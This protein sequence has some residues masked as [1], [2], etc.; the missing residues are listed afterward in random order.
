MLFD[1]ENIE[2]AGSDNSG[3]SAQLVGDV[4]GKQECDLLVELELEPWGL[5]RNVPLTKPTK[6]QQRGSI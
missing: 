1:M 5:R 3:V 2:R 4:W 6:L